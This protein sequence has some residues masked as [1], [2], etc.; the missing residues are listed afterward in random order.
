MNA[1]LQTTIFLALDP[2]DRLQIATTIERL[3]NL[4]DEIDGDPD[5]EPSLSGWQGGSDDRE[6]DAGDEQEDCEWLAM[7]LG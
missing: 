3:I 5:F 1:Q 2:R 6:A 4:L 7:A